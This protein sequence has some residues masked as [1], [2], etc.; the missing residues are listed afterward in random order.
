MYKSRKRRT[1][2]SDS[3]S[4]PLP[5]Q[6]SVV[7][8]KS[9]QI[10]SYF[11]DTVSSCGF[12]FGV[13]NK[14]NGLACDQAVFAYKLK[15]KLQQH[16]S[17][18]SNI[19]EFVENL[20][21]FINNEADL[22]KA[23]TDTETTEDCETT[24]GNVQASLLQLLLTVDCV[25]ARVMK[26]LFEKL[27]EFSFAAESA[28]NEDEFPWARLI[29]RQMRFLDNIV[30]PKFLSTQLAEV[31][32]AAQTAVQREV[33]FC[34]PDII[35]D[36]QHDEIAQKLSS[37]LVEKS[38]L[39]PVILDALSCLSVAPDIRAEVVD[40]VLTVLRTAPTEF[41][42]NVVKFLHVD[43][44]VTD[45]P[46]IVS[47]L[48]KGL[49]FTPLHGDT[50]AAESA[51]VLTVTALR[52]AFLLSKVVADGWLK[53]I[54]SALDPVPL[55]I[56]VLVVIHA[57]LPSR[58]RLVELRVRSKI[59]SGVFSEALLKK[60]FTTMNAVLRNYHDSLLTIASTL[61]QTA[62]SAASSHASYWFRLLLLHFGGHF[63]QETVLK[64]MILTCADNRTS[65][66]LGLDVLSSL[67]RDCAEC[68]LPNRLLLLNLLHKLTK[69]DLGQ[70]EQVMDVLCQLAYNPQQDGNDLFQDE[71]HMVICKK[72]SS[73]TILDK[74]KGVIGAVMA[75]KAIAS[76]T[77]NISQN[78]SSLSSDD[79]SQGTMRNA[80][81][82][83][84]L[85]MAGTKTYPEA[86]GLFFDEM[87][88][89]AAKTPN[90]GESFIAWINEKLLTD[91]EDQYIADVSELRLEKGFAIKFE[92]NN[93]ESEI[94]L[95]L[96]QMVF[97]KQ[98]AIP[99]K[100][101]LV[102]LNSYL[103]LLR[104]IKM[105]TCSGVLDEIDALL[106]CGVVMPEYEDEDDFRFMEPDQKQVILD[107]LFYCIN[108]FREL[109]N[110]F[111]LQKSA[112][113]KEKVMVRLRQVVDLEHRLAMLMLRA[114]EGYEPPPCQFYA[115]Q[116]V[117][118][119]S[120]KPARDGKKPPGKRGRK[121]KASKKSKEAAEE[122]DE[123]EVEEEVA[124]AAASNITSSGTLSVDMRHHFLRELDVD[125]L[126][127]L[128]RPLNTDE[129]TSKDH[130]DIRTLLF[131]LH[132][133]VGKLEHLYG[134]GVKTWPMKP[135][136]TMSLPVG[137]TNACRH[138][139][140]EF[141]PS[142]IKVMQKLCTKLETFAE[143]FQGLLE[144]S[145]GITDAPN[146]FE[147]G[148]VERKQCFR[149]ILQSLAIFYSWHGFES[150]ENLDRLKA[151]LKVCGRYAG[152]ENTD[153][154]VDSLV[155]ANFKY[156]RSYAKCTLQLSAA[157][158]LVTLLQRITTFSHESKPALRKNLAE[159]CRA[160]LNR[161]WFTETGSPETGA[162]CGRG[163]R[164]L[165][166]SY[167]SCS[168]DKLQFLRDTL[169]EVREEIEQHTNNGNNN[170]SLQVF[171]TVN[172]SNFSVLFVQLF[173]C[174]LEGA[175]DAFNSMSSS[176][177]QF[178]VW[179][180]IVD[181]LP[182]FEAIVKIHSGGTLSAVIR[183]SQQ[184]LKLFLNSGIRLMDAFLRDK[185]EEVIL[186]LKDLQKYN[187]FLHNLCFY[188]KEQKNVAVTKFVPRLRLTLEQLRVQVKSVLAAN[189]C[190]G[191]FTAGNLR[192]RNLQGEVI[193]SQSTVDG[194]EYDAA[195]QSNPDDDDG[196]DD[197]DDDDAEGDGDD[198]EEEE[199]PDEN[200]GSAES[201]NDNRSY[202]EEL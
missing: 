175:E 81:E 128:C 155:R 137:F 93:G 187:R 13:G 7:V 107:S 53:V 96:A 41:F 79:L 30:D 172:K 126:V 11:D 141:L 23:L 98:Q 164:I 90:L 51:K 10:K 39:T 17:F 161:P 5:K 4:S 75:A 85:V 92:E 14:P 111:V 105:L 6:A 188:T 120:K 63:A 73:S 45:L 196:G 169:S 18:P 171:P 34:L 173:K 33:I 70:V 52:D 76:R 89:I 148:S 3:S 47:G 109:I 87:S 68:L 28:S 88:L 193:S 162:A 146:M 199:C 108:W 71:I 180:L 80:I 153:A 142:A 49:D 29:L 78:S 19:D 125:V 22:K 160:F 59:K 119:M 117:A 200:D 72:V 135:A 158:S 139:S 149:L 143:Y 195:G 77:T 121:R 20:E 133:Y 94:C 122:E 97:E 103:R 44:S 176:E 2:S 177:K 138:S 174:L 197:D 140:Q 26:L 167:I 32:D 132:D 65:S 61:L 37:L 147:A 194:G 115:T 31:L 166:S 118:Q 16:H 157:C 181:F 12:V 189:G 35:C 56:V 69:F 64:L 15:N 40:Q 9:K 114:P 179:R 84:D 113:L 48:R 110:A 184:L 134:G 95:P 116:P 198:P 25:Q 58:Q 99:G 101:N 151:A 150:P 62:D 165:L 130:L 178:K 46:Q 168:S 24:R 38:E 104:L 8:E 91:F 100:R 1:V 129:T 154:S 54:E 145:D 156:F 123:P 57:A 86:Q 144:A 152:T 106:V 67:V 66:R 42:P 131:L 192:N 74:K 102:I 190:I 27:L 202:S 201:D 191:A 170:W 136:E 185:R 183:M 163:L 127:L 124:P 60:T 186:L 43:A 159:V 36:E 50:E 21:T 182:E 82:L 55:D 83:M 112:L